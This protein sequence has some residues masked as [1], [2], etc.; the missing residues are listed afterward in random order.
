MYVSD[1]KNKYMF[2][3]NIRTLP[4]F[5]LELLPILKNKIRQDKSWGQNLVILLFGHI[6]LSIRIPIN[7][8]L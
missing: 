7:T 6:K 5:F 2:F 4:N 1:N 8:N 3:C